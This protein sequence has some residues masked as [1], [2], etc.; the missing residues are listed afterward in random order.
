MDDVDDLPRDNLSDL[1]RLILVSLLDKKTHGAGLS[2]PTFHQ[3]QLERN[4]W[5]Y[6]NYFHGDT[7]SARASLSRAYRRLEDRGYIHKVKRRWVLTDPPLSLMKGSPESGVL[8]ALSVF[9]DL[10][11]GT[12]P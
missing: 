5:L 11:K 9:I 12:P 10:L 1:Q 7:P 8:T 4:R 6:E 3:T 2:D